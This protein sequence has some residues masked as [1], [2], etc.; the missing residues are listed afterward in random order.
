MN[1]KDR[2]RHV[3]LADVVLFSM[4]GAVNWEYSIRAYG[5]RTAKFGLI[6]HIICGYYIGETL[7]RLFGLN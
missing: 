3:P 7:I 5:R 4:C 2:N 1:N 6:I